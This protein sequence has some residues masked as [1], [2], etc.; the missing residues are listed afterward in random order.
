M[1][2]LDNFEWP[3]TFRALNQLGEGLNRSGL[4]RVDLSEEALLA[5]AC[6]RTG[7]TDWG[8]E[9][10]R[11]GLRVLLEAGRQETDLS[12]LGRVATR[13]DYLRLLMNR[14]RIQGAL[15]RN[16]AILDLPLQ[17]PLFIVGFPRTGSTLLHNLLSLDPQT[18]VPLMWEL[19]R[20]AP[21]S[22]GGT[23]PRIRQA[24]RL[25]RVAH[26]MAPALRYTHPV[27]PA[28][29]EE[30]FFLL[31]NEFTC[32]EFEV[33][34]HVPRY[35]T[36][37]FQQDLIPA[38]ESYRR[39]LLLLHW[40]RPGEHWVLKSPF[41][42]PGLEALLAVFPDACVVQTHRH[43]AEVV[44]SMCS[45]MGM[46]R[47]AHATHVDSLQLGADWLDTW[48]EAMSRASRIRDTADPKRFFDIE[49]RELVS[50][51]LGMVERLYDHLGYAFTPQLADRMRAWLREN[52]HDKH[53]THRTLW[54]NS[55]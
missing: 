8:G 37:F 5:E 32:L 38:Y 54:N 48:G 43:P 10:F 41:H 31:E 50:D 20:P 49:Y 11:A 55:G 39:Q 12:F 1:T 52:Q 16:P 42:L 13:G 24:T 33:R 17:Q 15:K 27:R 14:L 28:G 9:S 2:T 40:Q 7:L 19:L 44:P 22:N 26:A 4:L 29:P 45:V 18:R 47:K 53:G 34:R 21:P 6:R 3:W 36:W 23:D 30:C 35:V 46:V 25:A 51:P